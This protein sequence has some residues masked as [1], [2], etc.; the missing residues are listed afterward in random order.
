MVKCPNCN[1]DF[2]DDSDFCPY[3]GKEAPKIKIR[4][5]YDIKLSTQKET[6]II[7]DLNDNSNTISKTEL[8]PTQI[9]AVTSKADKLIINAGPGA[10]KTRVLV[11][12][13]KYLLN[14]RNVNPN[15]LLVITFTEKAAQEIEYRL[16]KDPEISYE[17]IDQMQIGTIHSFCRTFLR[18]YIS[19]GIEVIDDEDNDKKI[20]F[21]K[22]NLKRLFDDKY[23]YFTD[24]E[25][26]K[27][28]ERFDEFASFDIDTKR[29]EKYIKNRYFKLGDKK[30]DK[31]Y[32]EFIDE[33]LE[34]TDKFPR[35]E[36][37]ENSS[38]KRRLI[39]HNFLAISKAYDT[40]KEL[41]YE[42]KSYDFNLLQSK[43]RD[44]LKE[45]E[46]LRKKV[47]YKNI[48]IDEFQDTD[49]VQYEIFEMLAEYSETVT[50]VGDINQSIYR[51]RGSNLRNFEKLIKEKEN[52][53]FEVINLL[54]NYRSPKNIV[55][56]NNKFMTHKMPLTAK[57]QNNGDLYYLNSRDRGE[58]AQKIVEVIKYLK[59]NN[60]I[61]N[62]FDVGLLFRSTT[63]YQIESLL[64]EL[65]ANNINYH[66]KGFSDFQEYPEV[67]STILLLWYLSKSMIKT[68][69]FNLKEFTNEDLNKVMFKLSVET[70]E[71]LENYEG[72]PQEFSKMDL[73]ELIDLGITNKHDLNFFNE[74]N[75]LKK[76]FWT[77]NNPDNDILKL[78]YDLFS[79]TGYI[80]DTF[81]N[82]EDDEID[83]NIELLN[84]ALISNKINDFM[85]TYD[86]Y[87][88]DSFFEFIF[89]YYTEYSS[90]ANN[91]SSEDAVQI[92]TIHAAKGLEFPAVFI[93]SLLE[94]GFPR[95]KPFKNQIE[96]YPIPDKLK[97]HELYD[98]LIEQ[99]RDVN[100]D[101][102]FEL[103]KEYRLEEK[104]VLYVGLT[105][106]QSTLIISHILNKRKKE[107]HE[108]KIMK[109]TNPGFE[110]LKLDNLGELNV[111]ESK[112]ELKDDLELSF[113]SLGYYKKCPRLFNLI[114][115][116]N[117]VSPQN[118][119]MRIGTIIHA[120]LDK[121]N[122]EIISNKGE[123]SV[124]FIDDVI[125]E[126]LESN[127]DLKDNE[128]FIELL[129]SVKYYCD[130]LDIKLIKEDQ[131]TSGFDE[132]FDDGFE[133]DGIKRKVVESEYPF[134]IPWHN[135]KLRGTIDLIL[136]REDGSIDLV[137][138]K[139]SE[140][141][142]IGK[143]IETY[144]NQLHFY[145][146]AMNQNSNYQNNLENT[147]LQIYSLGDREYIDVRL[148]RERVKELDKNVLRVSDKINAKEYGVNTK[149]CDECLL[150]SLC[151]K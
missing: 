47:V 92:S 113:T 18:T 96:D 58:Q 12:R 111:V 121:I 31:A 78:Y 50:Y 40:Y 19:S 11:E 73:T 149:F 61:K 33:T 140:E 76:R 127:P 81:E 131:D 119:G 99:G 41:F 15:S 102:P 23:T 54:T 68:D 22:K 110:E 66:I 91:I 80:V 59:E 107:S 72:S 122:K 17:K 67:Q 89:N 43:T 130:T 139:T 45:S 34:K 69:L 57:N 141:E 64:N 138:F 143:Y 7:H 95:R 5:K 63:I 114:Q 77:E 88:L 74:L 135:S 75:K 104:R 98:E 60:K 25:L 129:D 144:Y 16:N 52:N 21:I 26:K 117:F 116:Y 14:E 32:R 35:A 10:G 56:F 82:M 147:K 105:R 28:A 49:R 93:C 6:D 46:K 65:N 44:S 90:P 150:R 115:N 24:L 146:M 55:E 120:V 133:C 118:I 86:R 83:S 1:K 79:I 30:K 128:N 9:E 97:Y 123:I 85:E 70:I 8:S 48:L 20:L 71:L 51:W 37:E 106:A 94:G 62:Y 36:I 39:A 87:D 142:S 148:D 27:V 112:E 109:E 42:R 124:G 29:L 53:G 3:C 38:H 125:D 103:D 101:Y 84:L 108:F 145:F 4:E 151:C 100:L 2:N 126:A 132:F 13:V 137:D 134:T 136:S